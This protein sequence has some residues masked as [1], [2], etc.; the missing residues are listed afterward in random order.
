V[1]Q[2]V[3]CLPNKCG[4]LISNFQCH[5]E[6]GEREWGGKRREGVGERRREENKK[7]WDTFDSLRIIFHL[8]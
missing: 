7:N 2:V 4:E 6:E 1:T 8:G 3:D 5:K